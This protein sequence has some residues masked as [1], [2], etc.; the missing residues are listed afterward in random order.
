MA[1]KWE[2]RPGF[3]GAP[4]ITTPTGE[5][6]AEVSWGCTMGE[7]RGPEG[8]G[9]ADRIMANARLMAAAPELLAACSH[10]LAHYELDPELQYTL[11]AAIAKAKGTA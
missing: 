5:K 4:I 6:I 9:H 11:R 7:L 1:T 8:A 2:V 10:A 3:I